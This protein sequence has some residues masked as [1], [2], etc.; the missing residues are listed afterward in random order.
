MGQAN[1][2]SRN[3]HPDGFSHPHRAHVGA[4]GSA[5]F[6]VIPASPIPRCILS[7]DYFQ[8]SH[9]FLSKLS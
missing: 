5:N 3:F 6:R 9:S 2:L 7:V 1:L 8:I 4:R